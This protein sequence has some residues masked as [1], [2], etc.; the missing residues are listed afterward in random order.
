M[1]PTV[2]DI[3]KADDPRDVIHRAVQLLAD[4]ELVA[5]PTETVYVVCAYS[6]SSEAV[7]RLRRT[8]NSHGGP[9]HALAIKGA[10]EALDYVPRMTRLGRKLARRCWPGPVTIE[11]DVSRDEG[12]VKSLPAETCDAVVPGGAIRLR[13]PAHQVLTNVL[14]LLPAP[15]VMS[16]ETLA[17]AP[18]ATTAEQVAERFAG[19]LSLIIDDG[20]CRYAEPAT[21]VHVSNDEWRLVE[22]GVVTETTLSRLASEAYL[23]VCS[24]NTCRSP[25]A[26]GLFR[27]F[28]AKELQCCE[29]DL[30]DRGFVVASAGLAAAIGAPASPESVQLLYKHGIDLRGHESQPLSNRLLDQADH[31]YAMTRGHRD[32][33][34]SER[35]ELS[36]RVHLLSAD[37]GD[38]SDPIGGGMSEYE[39]CQTEI[40]NHVR[41]LLKNIRVK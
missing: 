7:G 8:F 28:M 23:F 12:L 38:V 11:F 13:V 4:G 15:V 1:M 29:D 10:D 17:D 19:A 36:N 26:E 37:G 30:V 31:I 25:M 32:A 9:P 5:F 27:K 3:Q 22:P 6:L 24:G 16:A 2:V 35:P 40:E 39:R 18:A 34:L 41:A 33:I 20:S 21:V 14:K